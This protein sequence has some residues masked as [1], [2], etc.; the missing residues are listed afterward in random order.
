M[1]QIMYDIWKPHYEN[2][3]LSAS[4]TLK[5]KSNEVD[6]AAKLLKNVQTTL[7]NTRIYT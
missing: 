6:F 7:S 3:K 5:I 2:R 4:F 1:K